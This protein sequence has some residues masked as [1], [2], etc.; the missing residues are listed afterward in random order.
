MLK[1]FTNGRFSS[2][3]VKKICFINKCEYPG[4]EEQKDK[5]MHATMTI[6]GTT[7]MF[8]DAGGQMNVN[9]GDNFSVSLDFK[10]DGDMQ[11]T[12][13]ALST[14]GVVKM[15]LQDTFWGAKFGMCTDKFDVNWMCNHDKPKG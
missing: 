3:T 12:F 8:S 6:M 14:G 7:V 1:N 9:F 15:P 2:R 13:D 5:V 10:H 4:A 11:R